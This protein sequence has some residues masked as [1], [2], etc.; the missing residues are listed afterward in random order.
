MPFDWQHS[1]AFYALACAFQ[2]FCLCI[3]ATSTICNDIY[4]VVYLLLLVAHLRVLNDRIVR[5]GS[6]CEFEYEY[7]NESHKEME[8]HQQLAECVRDH[9]EC[10]RFYNCIRPPIAATIF[11]QFVSTALALCTSAA[12]FVSEDFSLLQLM[13]FFLYSVVVL[14]EIAPCCWFMD[15]ALAQMHKLTNSLFSCRWYEQDH[16]FRRSLIIFMQRSQVADKILAGNIAP[17]SLDTFVKI[18][19]FA[20]SLFTLLKQ[21]K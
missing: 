12:A 11:I 14:F 13:K 19:K 17:V 18:I 1:M 3:H 5:L 15:E 20:F 21:L 6:A 4:S 16:K 9:K 2:I 7:M 10:M 8:H